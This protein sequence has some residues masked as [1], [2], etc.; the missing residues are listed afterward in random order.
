MLRTILPPS[1]STLIHSLRFKRIGEALPEKCI[2]AFWHSR[3]IGGWWFARE[4]AVALVSKSKDG[5]YLNGILKRWSYKTVR[6]SSS[7][8]GKQA[9]D[10]AMDLIR[11]GEANR[12]VITP[13]GPR[14]PKEI[15]KRGAFIAAQELNLPLYFL[16]IEY[17]DAMHLHKSWD[18][19]QIPYPL[20]S[21]I[22]RVKKIDTKG[23][24][25]DQDEQ[26]I[27][28]EKI[29]APYATSPIPEK[30]EA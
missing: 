9:L 24:P 20:S 3:M 30:A 17:K 14:G 19:F 10:E 16:S 6:G 12:L 25:S 23:F 1:V 15:F 13:D 2:V 11:R 4:N 22:V 18:R 5:E 7:K 29:S 21:V 8:S 28:L 26:K 27:F